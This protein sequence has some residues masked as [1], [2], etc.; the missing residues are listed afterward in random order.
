M[1]TDENAKLVAQVA[2]LKEKLAKATE[3]TSQ[4]GTAA[5]SALES[6]DAKADAKPKT[7]AK[8]AKA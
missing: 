4:A 5:A 2:D 8:A 3:P 1:V 6:T 7:D